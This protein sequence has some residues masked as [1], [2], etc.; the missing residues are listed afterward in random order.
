LS[1]L[2][3]PCH[4]HRFKQLNSKYIYRISYRNAKK[5]NPKKGFAQTEKRY[6]KNFEALIFTF[7]LQVFKVQ[8]I[9]RQSQMA[10]PS[11]IYI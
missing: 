6:H 4:T 8:M 7:S 5:A 3:I 9:K 11:L 1:K 2:G 10:L